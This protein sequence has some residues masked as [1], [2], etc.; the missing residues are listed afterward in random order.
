MK[1][2]LTDAQ[3]KLE[4]EVIKGHPFSVVEA[5]VFLHDVLTQAGPEFAVAIGLALRKLE[6]L[7]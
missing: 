6:E 5:P 7:S 3:A 1:D 4:M 2:V